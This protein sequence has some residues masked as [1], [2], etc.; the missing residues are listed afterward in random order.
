MLGVDLLLGVELLFQC[1][2]LRAC[3]FQLKLK[4][5]HNPILPWREG[6]RG[7]RVGR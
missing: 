6:I 4:P 5:F 2:Y 1:S 7:S 3:L